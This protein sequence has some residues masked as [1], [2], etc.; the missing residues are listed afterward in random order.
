MNDETMIG[1]A[2]AELAERE[3]WPAKEV[4][5]MLLKICDTKDQACNLAKQLKSLGYME[6]KVMVT[7]KARK[8][9][10]R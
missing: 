8:R 3:L 4:Q 2:V 10:A 6:R 5:R 7:E 9:A 1:R